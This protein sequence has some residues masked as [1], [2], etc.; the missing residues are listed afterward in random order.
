MARTKY[1]TQQKKSLKRK[2]KGK[3]SKTKSPS[4]KKK[5]LSQLRDKKRA[6]VYRNR[7]VDSKSKWVIVELADEITFEDN[8]EVIEHDVIQLFWD[9]PYFIP[10]YSEEINGE[11]VSITLF[12]GYFFVKLSDDIVVNQDNLKTEHIKGIMKRNSKIV[13]IS[14]TKINEFKVELK[15][16]LLSLAP[17]RKQLISPKIGILSNL[18]GEVISVNKKKLIFHARFKCSTRLIEA[19]VSFINY[20]SIS[21][22]ELL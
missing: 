16:K 15:N 2:T 12:D 9:L 1:E 3:P 19:P 22:E 13:E 20:R 4:K 11:A 21:P 6:I 5:S 14:G 10:V 8:S 7:K 17:Q 18:K